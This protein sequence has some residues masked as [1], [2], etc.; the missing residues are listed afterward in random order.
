LLAYG[1]MTNDMKVKCA[2]NRVVFILVNF[3]TTRFMEKDVT[4]WLTE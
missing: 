2:C 3:S 4:L 1:G